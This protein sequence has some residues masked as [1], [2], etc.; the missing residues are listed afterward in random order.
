MRLGIM[1]KKI[2]KLTPRLQATLEAALQ[3]NQIPE[4]R[5]NA[6]RAWL[7]EI[8]ADIYGVLAVGPAFV[9]V[10]MDFLANDKAVITQDKQSA[11][12]WTNYPTDYLRILLNLK[13]LSHQGFQDESEN[14]KTNW[15]ATYP[16]HAMT[17]FE[18]DIPTIVEGLLNGRY[19]EFGG[20]TLPEII[21]FSGKDHD[22]SKSDAE[23]ILEGYDPQAETVP[24]LFASVRLA[25]EKKPEE[26]GKKSEDSKK[27]SVQER[28][29]NRISDMRELGVRFGEK[30]DLQDPEFLKTLEKHDNEA[31]KKLF[32][33][34]KELMEKQK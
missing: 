30:N 33:A 25:F 28:I 3:A 18:Q 20:V 34:I 26:F 5:K 12:Y 9:G 23:L 11:P 15:R 32:D 6:W 14:L 8:F 4:D 21:S 2:L 29:L 24:S 22:R 1:W 27:K 7:G 17:E 19:P 31:G 13:V 10:L 16:S